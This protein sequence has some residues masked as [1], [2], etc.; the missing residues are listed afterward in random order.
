[1]SGPHIL[2]VGSGSAGQRHA[3]NLAELGCRISCVDPRQDRREELSGEVPVEDAYSGLT[4]ALG[5]APG[6]Q[7]AVVASPPSF[8]VDQALALIDADLPMLLEKPVAP[9]L[10]DAQRLHAAC[11][12]KDIPL[13][14]GYTWRWWPPL[15][16][17]K[18]LLGQQVIGTLHHVHFIMSAHLADWHPW[19]RY[20]DFFMANKDQGG[21]ALLDESHWVDLMVW[22]F[23][24]P[25][26]V[27]ATID[28]VSDL[29]IDTDDS[30]DMLIKYDSG[31]HVTLH[32]D[33]YGRPH[34][35][36]IRFSGDKGVLLWTE[37]PNRIAITNGES[38]QPEERHFTCDRNDMFVAMAGEFLRV[39]EGAAP[40]TCRL[41]DGIAV[42]K[43]LEA[44]RESHQT[45]RFVKT[46][47]G[48]P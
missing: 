3:R 46:D 10:A 36:S 5:A 41:E 20:Q 18:K 44:A 7:G 12:G 26:G 2:I 23:G 27:S 37:T 21:G 30:V 34:E 28:K 24:M 19:E 17:V 25:A 13:L 31:L 38:G 1:M 16:D 40:T 8:H 45:G 47:Q 6:L 33:L 4:E 48:K 42:L 32:L 29:E 39:L 43:I 35:K 22:M 14:L 9:H 11:Q 15:A